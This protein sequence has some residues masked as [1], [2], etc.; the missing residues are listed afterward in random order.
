M[1]VNGLTRQGTANGGTLS[2]VHDAL[3]PF[4][5]YSVPFRRHEMTV[6]EIIIAVLHCLSKGQRVGLSACVRVCVYAV[7]LVSASDQS[8]SETRDIVRHVGVAIIVMS[9]NVR[10]ISRYHLI[11]MNPSPGDNL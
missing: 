9:T 10:S 8:T 3:L 7:N 11:D 1:L 2:T 6:V 5:V 4:A